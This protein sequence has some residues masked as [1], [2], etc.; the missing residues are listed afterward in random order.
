[1]NKSREQIIQSVYG[2]FN[3]RDIPAVLA[4]MH[5]HV[6]WPNGWEGGY[7]EG[8][9]AVSNYWTRQWKE[10][11][12]VVEPISISI[13]GNK[14]DVTVRQIVKNKQGQLL[15]DGIVL[16]QYDIEDG[17]IR[18]MEIIHGQFTPDLE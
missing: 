3:R 1:M 9:E 11:D 17:L 13:S 4:F 7:V 15:S 10:L 5:P 16:H 6:H 8:H 18:G 2:A 14:A 12:P